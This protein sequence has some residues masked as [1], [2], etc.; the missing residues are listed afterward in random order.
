M[1][2]GAVQ[3]RRQVVGFGQRSEQRRPRQPGS[4]ISFAAGGSGSDLSIRHSASERA[5]Q[6]FTDTEQNVGG[7]ATKRSQLRFRF[8]SSKAALPRPEQ[9]QG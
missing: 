7:A 6:G 4:V 8:E 5:A 2:E 1:L 3:Q 9:P